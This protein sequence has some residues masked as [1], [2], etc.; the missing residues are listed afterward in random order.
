MRKDEPRP[1]YTMILFLKSHIDQYTRKDGSIVQAH[2]DNRQPAQI[3]Q[4]AAGLAG[5]K[6]EQWM[7][8]HQEQ[9]ER[10]HQHMPALQREMA[11][12]KATQQR[13]LEEHA[14]HHGLANE[15]VE[16]GDNDAA[17][18]HGRL[19]YEASLRSFAAGA[20]HKHASAEYE[21][22]AKKVEALQKK[23]EKILPGV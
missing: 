13:E 20:K 22:H 18:N 8:A 5:P 16:R 11:E 10:M 14:K 19:A 2:D 15:A 3:P 21:K 1:A 4:A 23:K 7:A 6:R 9:H 12:H 17:V